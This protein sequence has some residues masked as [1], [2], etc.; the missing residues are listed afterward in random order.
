MASS[1]KDEDYRQ[2]NDQKERRRM[3]NRV[4]QQRYRM[5][6]VKPKEKGPRTRTQRRKPSPSPN[7]DN[8]GEYHSMVETTAENGTEATGQSSQQEDPIVEVDNL[9]S[10]FSESDQF[11]PIPTFETKDRE[12]EA[13]I[14][15]H[16]DG[17]LEGFDEIS[18]DEPQVS[19][20]PLPYSSNVGHVAGPFQEPIDLLQWNT[21]PAPEW[22]SALNFYPNHQEMDTQSMVPF[23]NAFSP[24]GTTSTIV[25]RTSSY[26]KEV[27]NYSFSST[28]A[29]ERYET[30]STVVEN[31]GAPTWDQYTP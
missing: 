15:G 16:E 20:T 22:I 26:K 17:I 21:T 30:S 24:F 29:N 8:V 3:Q 5:R 2:A 12:R 27:T 28:N 18:A 23:N 6:H 31:W 11:S 7:M 10:W 14:A 9:S 1:S 25:P 19:T 4:N 13:D